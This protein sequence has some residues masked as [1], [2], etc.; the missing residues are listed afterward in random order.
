[1]DI[2]NKDGYGR[3]SYFSKEKIEKLQDISAQSTLINKQ[4]SKSHEDLLRNNI[5]QYISLVVDKHVDCGLKAAVVM[6]EK[7]IIPQKKKDAIISQL[8]RL[9]VK[10]TTRVLIAFEDGV[11]DC[12]YQNQSTPY[13]QERGDLN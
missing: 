12:L 2:I 9:Q 10:V 8:R 13:G 5:C 7:G 11:L 1:M 3:E 6:V 4:L